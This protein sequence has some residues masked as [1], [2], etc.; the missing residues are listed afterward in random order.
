MRIEKDFIFFTTKFPVWNN[1][2]YK[3]VL[4]GRQFISISWM[5]NEFC[6]VVQK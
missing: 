4:N 5:N 2:K 1:I 6:V 3:L